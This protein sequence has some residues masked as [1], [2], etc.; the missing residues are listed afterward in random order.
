MNLTTTRQGEVLVVR[1]E[2]S[3]LDASMA[4]QFKDRLGGFIAEGE[5]RLVLDLARVEFIDSSGL[6]VLVAL[7]KRQGTEGR[8]ALAAL[9]PPVERLL[10]LTRLDR[11]FSIHATVAAAAADIAAR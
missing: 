5:R 4:V 9:R 1:P 3:R 2:L 11:V 8:L 6:G 10:A 7:L